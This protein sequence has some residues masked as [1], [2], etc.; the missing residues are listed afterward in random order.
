[1]DKWSDE[2]KL[3]Q[4]S[5]LRS[6]WNDCNRCG[7][8][9]TRNLVVFGEGHPSARIMFIGEA[10]GEEEDEKGIPFCG[11]SGNLFQGFLLAAGIDKNA[12]FVT[13]ILGCRPP[14]NRD[15]Q[16]VERDACLERIHKLIYLIDPLLVV[17][18]G[19]IA[20]KALAKGRDWSI[21]EKSGSLFSSAHPFFKTPGDQNGMA[22]PGLVFPKVDGEKRKY[23]LEYDMIPIVHPAFVLRN[24]SFD[25]D[26]NKFSTKG[27]AEKTGDILKSIRSLV[28]DLSAEHERIYQSARRQAW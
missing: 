24:D 9:E 6:D 25:P 13:N 8:S 4:L 15:P 22:V 17:P 12:V 1:M 27:W 11:A 28:D 7:L 21:L 14:G 2:W 16:L 18:V 5:Q 19:A 3:D 20:L 26:T 10:P 23:C